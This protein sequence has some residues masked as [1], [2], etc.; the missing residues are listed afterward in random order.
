[1]P[2]RNL[3]D[4][5]IVTA[6]RPLWPW[7]VG[8]G[9]VIV[10]GGATWLMTH[11]AAAKPTTVTKAPVHHHTTR[12]TSKFQPQ[13]GTPN[14]V[15]KSQP[16]NGQVFQAMAAINDKYM[17]WGDQQI[18]KAIPS[19]PSRGPNAGMLTPA[20]LNSPWVL[21][22]YPGPKVPTSL[23]AAGVKLPAGTPAN[24]SIVGLS[25]GDMQQA[26]KA[27]GFFPQLTPQQ[28]LGAYQ[29]AAKYVMASQG[30]NPASSIQYNDPYADG[31]QEDASWF[32]GSHDNAAW[33]FIAPASQGGMLPLRQVNYD[34]W[35][36]FTLNA[37]NYY[38]LVKVSPVVSHPSGHV[39]VGDVGIENI[40]DHIIGSDLVNGKL[41]IGQYSGSIGEVSLAL[42]K[43]G[44]QERWYVTAMSGISGS[45]TPTQTYWTAPAK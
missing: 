18:A 45:N 38:N 40:T 19:I 29:T 12:P 21:K 25:L 5:I 22:H 10:G 35:V 42:I 13:A 23:A 31:G 44:S 7:L 28:L 14:Y 32:A 3:A 33:N 43:D 4:P 15:P 27:T 20:I 1:M 6:R 39:V 11:Q 9:V 16:K 8:A 24:G 36:S 41:V 2:Q 37:G 17:T 26:L 30:N 34:N